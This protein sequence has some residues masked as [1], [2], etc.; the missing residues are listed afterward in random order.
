MYG[1]LQEERKYQTNIDIKVLGYL[2]GASSNEARPKL[3]VRENA[4]EV[5]IPREH[6]I[7]DDDNT[8]TGESFYRS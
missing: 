6:V 7:M 4:V 3:T 8:Y 2:L 5:K 1:R